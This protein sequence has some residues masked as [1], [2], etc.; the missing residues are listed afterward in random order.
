[1]PPPSTGDVYWVEP[2]SAQAAFAVRRELLRHRK[3][4]TTAFVSITDEKRH[5]AV[6]TQHFLNKQFE[7]WQQQQDPDNKFWAWVGHSDN[8]S[9]FKSGSMMNYWSRV[10]NSGW[11]K[12]VWVEFGC[13]GHGKGPWDGMGAVI[14][15]QLTRDL[16]KA[17]ILTD[18]GYVTC[19]REA[20]EHLRRRFETEAWREKHKHMPINEI[21]VTYSNHE[22]INRPV[23]EHEFDP[24]NGKL[25]TY[26]YMMLAEDQIAARRRSCWCGACIRARG[27]VNMRS[28]GSL[29]HAEGC[30]SAIPW[31]QQVVQDKGTGLAGRRREAQKRGK[32]LAQ[33]LMAAKQ[34]NHAAGFMAIQAR[35]GWTISDDVHYRPGH[36]WIAQAPDV[37]D[38]RRIDS[39]CSIDGTAFSPGDYLVRIGRYFD[40]KASDPSG[41]TFEEWTPPECS[42]GSH[43]INATELRAVNFSMLPVKPPLPLQEVRRSRRLA[44]IVSIPPSP[45]PKVYTLPQIIDNEIRSACW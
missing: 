2:S 37:L 31:E 25:S 32:E 28:E 11:L 44:T 10:L 14:K 6:T 1:M 34:G 3:L 4:H 15:Q 16:T 18:D 43:I 9:H 26:S 36:F 22:D 38:V 5:D 39:R 21:K 20:A 33:K 45:P 12:N 8:A 35:E 40:R 30:T 7:Y 42:D 24:L 13:P 19:P 29:L 17:K 41:L 23:V 27:R